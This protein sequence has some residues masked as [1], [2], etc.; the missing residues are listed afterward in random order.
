MNF[1]RKKKLFIASFAAP[2]GIR[3]A[4]E[5]I[6]TKERRPLKSESGDV[7]HYPSTSHYQLSTLY[8][9]LL[10][11]AIKH[12]RIGG[13]LVCWIPIYKSDYSDSYI[14]K[15]K[16]LKLIA[17]SEQVLSSIAARRLLTYE[18]I[19]EPD[20]EDLEITDNIR[21]DFR[22]RFFAEEDAER[23][24]KKM[25]REELKVIGR[26]EALKRGKIIVEKK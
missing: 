20:S 17:N 10:R 6:Q 25:Q 9:D 7:I 2:Y 13:R 16:Y 23:L 12:L 14:P 5:K 3:E 18:K 26:Q 19:R 11:F 22:P 1:K 4:R 24:E 15:S 8:A 21:D